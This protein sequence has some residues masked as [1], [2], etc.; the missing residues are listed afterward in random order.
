MSPPYRVEFLPSAAREFGALPRAVQLQLVAAVDGL[1]R[2]PRPDG[3]ALLSGTGSE[4][5]WRL[6]VGACRLLYQVTA[7]VLLVLVV[8]IADRRE[9]YRSAEMKALLKRIRQARK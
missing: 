3:A 9:V 5:I 8:R 7:E 4:R 2:E 6:R 1:A